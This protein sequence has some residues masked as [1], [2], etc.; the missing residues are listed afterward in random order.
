MDCRLD[1]RTRRLHGCLAV[2]ASRSMVM[3][4]GHS[5]GMDSYGMYLLFRMWIVIV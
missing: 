3:E 4:P 5:T 1:I 2:I